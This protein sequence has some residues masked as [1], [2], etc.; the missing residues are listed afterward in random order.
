MSLYWL[1]WLTYNNYNIG[2]ERDNRYYPKNI[3]TLKRNDYLTKKESFIEAMNN[4]VNDIIN[5]DQLSD[6]DV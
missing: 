3:E 1:F 2:K 6:D 5:S 4:V